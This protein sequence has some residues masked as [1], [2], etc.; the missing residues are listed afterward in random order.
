MNKKT[1]FPPIEPR[2]SGLLTVSDIHKIYWERSGNPAGEKILIIHGGPGG[3]SQPRYRRYFD[4]EKFD[5][6][7]FDQRGWGTA[8]QR[9]RE[10]AHLED[11]GGTAGSWL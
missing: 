6:I 10:P 11:T 9:S 4:P 1:L 2:E 8:C 3:G 5:I 7:Q